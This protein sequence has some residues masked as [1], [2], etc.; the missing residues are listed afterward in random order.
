MET[1]TRLPASTTRTLFVFVFVS[2]TDEHGIG[3]L[4]GDEDGPRVLGELVLGEWL[5]MLHPVIRIAAAATA[6]A[7][8]ESLT[9]HCRFV[10]IAFLHRALSTTGLK[11]R[12][13]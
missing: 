11:P 3:E 9:G 7:T 2:D 4:G 6:T 12:Q 10:L 8:V 5:A 13:P 1:L